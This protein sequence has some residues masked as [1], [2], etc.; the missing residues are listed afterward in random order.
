MR[1]D[2]AGGNGEIA[3]DGISIIVQA[4]DNAV[5]DAKDRP[6]RIP[7]NGG[8]VVHDL[9]GAS[10]GLHALTEAHAFSSIGF[11]EHCLDLVG[12]CLRQAGMTDHE[13]IVWYGSGADC[14]R[15]RRLL[16]ERLDR[17]HGEVDGIV[18]PGEVENS[19]RTPPSLGGRRPIIGGELDYNA[20][21]GAK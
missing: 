5:A 10:G 21:A 20:V 6:A 3:A 7:A 12:N 16:A 18:P 13:Q 1:A 4:S 2:G 19:G 14:E 8:G 9:A 15:Q 17:K 11:A